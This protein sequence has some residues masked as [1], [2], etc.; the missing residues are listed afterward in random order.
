MLEPYSGA[1]EYLIWLSMDVLLGKAKKSSSLFTLLEILEKLEHLD[2]VYQGIISK[3]ESTRALT[4]SLKSTK[5]LLYNAW[6]DPRVPTFAYQEVNKELLGL[7]D[8]LREGKDTPDYD[9]ITLY[10]GGVGYIKGKE[11]FVLFR[12]FPKN[13]TFVV[14]SNT[15][16]KL[17]EIVTNELLV[18]ISKSYSEM[19]NWILTDSSEYSSMLAITKQV[20]DYWESSNI[21]G[22]K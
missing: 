3:E 5:V 18:L 20:E 4:E 17:D 14:T 7:L 19:N 21:G 12:K 8:Q 1:Y 15:L 11:N 2:S 6:V 16:S 9:N 10:E 22:D 13:N